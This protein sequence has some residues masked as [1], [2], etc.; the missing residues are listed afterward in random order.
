MKYDLLDKQ[1]D[2]IKE[3]KFYLASLA[4]RKREPTE[5]SKNQYYLIVDRLNALGK[6]PI[7]HC[8]TKNTFYA[9]RAAW[10][11]VYLNRITNNLKLMETTYSEEESIVISE[12]IKLDMEKLKLFPPDCNFQNIKKAEQRLYR[13]E[14]QDV[15][16]LAPSS[17]SKKFQTNKLPSDWQDKVFQRALRQD[18]KYLDAIA[19][20]SISGCRPAEAETNGIG[21]Q[22]Q[23]DLSIKVIIRSK[24][25]HGGQYGQELRAF[26]VNSNS[27]EHVYLVNRM[28]MNDGDLYV[29]IDKSKNLSEAIRKLG[30]AVFPGLR[31]N[32]SPYNY[33]HAFSS[34]LKGV[35]TDREGVAK[36][37]GH[38]SD[39]S[40]R[41]YASGR[42]GKGGFK[43][44]EILGTNPVKVTGPQGT[45]ALVNISG[46][47]KQ[48]FNAMSP[49]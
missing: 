2:A 26:T 11:Y 15:K 46:L 13:S 19:V 25:T 35:K 4:K 47:N 41:F 6:T 20:L 29:S 1:E 17:K 12:K 40:Q 18:S 8:T 42:K 33:R 30:K 36:A 22:L 34:N 10:S 32:I 5:S 14:W 23:D 31:L 28:Q 44:K 24:K 48:C 3:A 21:L 9:Y 49:V 7:S 16:N 37:M 39:R 45:Q 38:S 43:I 27:V